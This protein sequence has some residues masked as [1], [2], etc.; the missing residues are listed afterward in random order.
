MNAATS[1][2]LE[3]KQPS[4]AP[5]LSA[6]ASPRPSVLLFGICSLLFFAVVSFG[7]VEEW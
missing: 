6:E 4:R 7:A 3:F 5:A 2:Q 1:A